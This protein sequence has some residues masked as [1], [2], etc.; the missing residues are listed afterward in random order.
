MPAGPA[1]ANKGIRYKIIRDRRTVALLK[2]EQV[3]LDA[4]A[5]IRVQVSGKSAGEA[6]LPGGQAA[7]VVDVERIVIVLP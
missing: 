6:E 7:Q 1:L 5:G 2:S 3:D 4:F